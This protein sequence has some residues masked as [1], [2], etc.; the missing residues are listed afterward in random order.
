MTSTDSAGLAEVSCWTP[1]VVEEIAPVVIR[2]GPLLVPAVEPLPRDRCALVLPLP[3]CDGIVAVAVFQNY[4]DA[5]RR[6]DCPAT[7]PFSDVNTVRRL[8]KLAF[9]MLSQQSA[10]AE[11]DAEIEQ[12]ALQIAHNYEEITLLYRLTR[13]AQVSLGC[14]AAQELAVSLLQD[15]VAVRQVAFVSYNDDGV[16]SRGSWE[17]SAFELRRLAN[18]IGQLAAD[19]PLV[20]NTTAEFRWATEFPQLERLVVVPI[21]RGDELIGWL[22]AVNSFDGKALGSVEAGLMTA[23]AAILATHH[24]HV[25]LFRNVEDLFLGVVRALTS[26]I[27]AK[28]PYT[29]GHS[30]R[31]AR[32]ARRLAQELGQPDAALDQ[33]YLSGLLHDVGK[34]GVEDAVLRKPDRLTDAEFEHIKRHP[35]VGYEILAGVGHLR[36]VLPGVRHHHENIDGTGY[37]DRLRGDDISLMAR[38]IA[39]ADA[40]DAMRSDRPYR[41]ALPRMRIDHVLS[42]G[43]GRQWDRHVVDAFWQ[44]QDEIE[45]TVYAGPDA[46]QAQQEPTDAASTLADITQF[47]S[48]NILRRERT[49]RDQA[50]PA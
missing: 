34:I 49:G 6:H 16:L 24:M 22:M 30:D 37:P 15:V 9:Q 17:L 19:R 27:D 4:G 35:C 42:S 38:I 31:V 40:Y 44:C 45:R 13:E 10:L 41:A 18:E 36:S 48:L 28:D 33:I 12:M 21:R 25:K 32:I 3:D 8:G 50:S 1:A 46:A 14:S 26:A 43:V 7:A 11:R 39:V 23:V 20:R 29:R 5:P 2:L 47:V